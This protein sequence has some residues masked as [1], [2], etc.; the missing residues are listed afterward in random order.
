MPLHGI[1]SVY[2]RYALRKNRSGISI[3]KIARGN[4]HVDNHSPHF[5]V[6]ERWDFKTRN[7]QPIIDYAM[8]CR[9]VDPVADVFH[10]AF[11]RWAKRAVSGRSCT[12]SFHYFDRYIVRIDRD[13][14]GP[15]IRIASAHHHSKRK[16]LF[17][18]SSSSGKLLS[19][20]LVTPIMLCVSLL[21]PRK[22]MIVYMVFFMAIFQGMGFWLPFVLNSGLLGI[23]TMILSAWAMMI[24]LIKWKSLRKNLT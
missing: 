2:L 4:C 17:I 7:Q 14:L 15:H 21:L 13:F 5:W 12:W 11:T 10:S 16:Y 9:A 6:Y 8:Y 22:L 3:S 18:H 23:V 19:P 24:G 1:R 20:L